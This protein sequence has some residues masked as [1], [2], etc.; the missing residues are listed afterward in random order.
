VGALRAWRL[1]GDTDDSEADEDGRPG[2]VPLAAKPRDGGL[3]NDN[4]AEAGSGC[5]LASHDDLVLAR[6]DAQ[7]G[8]VQIDESPFLVSVVAA[9][10]DGARQADPDTGACLCPASRP[11]VAGACVPLEGLVPSPA[12]LPGPLLSLLVTH[13][14]NGPALPAL[15][16]P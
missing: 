7:V 16:L 4:A 2:R 6:G 13:S 1:R 11:N 8:G 3:L 12:P 14:R 5:P 9:Q 10:C 15:D